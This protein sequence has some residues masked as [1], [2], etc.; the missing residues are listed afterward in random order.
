MK[1]A[2][3]FILLVAVITTIGYAQAPLNTKNSTFT[4]AHTADCKL[5]SSNSSRIW[6]TEL[7]LEA[8]V[9]KH[10]QQPAIWM[11][12]SAFDTV[13]YEATFIIDS[14]GKV[15]SVSLS[16]N[17][18]DTMIQAISRALEKV[19]FIPA[20]GLDSFPISSTWNAKFKGKSFPHS[21]LSQFCIDF[22]DSC[23]SSGKRL[24]P[25]LI[26]AVHFATEMPYL[27]SCK[28]IMDG[29]LKQT[30]SQKRIF[31][32][33]QEELLN[34]EVIK[35]E[36]PSGVAFVQYVVNRQGLVEGVKILRSTSSGVSINIEKEVVKAVSNLPLFIPG[37]NNGSPVSVVFT[38]PIRF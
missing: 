26:D 20:M 24:D 22:P 29:K 11:G 10:Y 7:G 19:Q 17:V 37:K 13:L 12:Y 32:F 28:E 35:E 5:T 27:A 36:K 15:G 30:C 8:Q 34:N 18:N 23:N 4:V 25:L 33:I 9:K 38:I 16:P 2:A 31:E 3:L 1:S 6:C 14:G 21:V